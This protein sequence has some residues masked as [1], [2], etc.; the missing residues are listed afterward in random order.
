MQEDARTVAGIFFA[1][2][3]NA[4]EM[5]Q[6]RA[7]AKLT[8]IT[9]ISRPTRRVKR[10]FFQFSEVSNSPHHVAIIDPPIKPYD[11]VELSLSCNLYFQC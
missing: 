11:E 2:T 10:N 4:A 7:T 5:V 6:K 1:N 8:D 9:A 3:K